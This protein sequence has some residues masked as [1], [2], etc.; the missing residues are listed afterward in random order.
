MGAKRKFRVPSAA[1]IVTGTFL[2]FF[3]LAIMVIDGGSADAQTSNAT[4]AKSAPVHHKRRAH[5]PSK[6]KRHAAKKETHKPRAH[7]ADTPA[8]LVPAVAS[9]Y[10]DEGNTACG[11]H[12]RYGVANKTLRCGT[13]VTIRYGDR[14]V[15]ATVDDRGPYVY[16]RSFDLSQNTAAALGMWGVATVDVSQV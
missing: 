11:F 13:K 4:A 12:A 9:W 8:Q 10:Y 1:A 3:P 14:S 2:L 7:V 16:G 5:K 15:V 6:V